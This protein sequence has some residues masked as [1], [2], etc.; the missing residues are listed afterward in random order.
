MPVNAFNICILL[1]LN[2]QNPYPI[3][4][5]IP[6]PLP[7]PI[8]TPLAPAKISS[9]ST[10]ALAMQIKC[11]FLDNMYKNT[12]RKLAPAGLSNVSVYS[13]FYPHQEKSLGTDSIDWLDIIYFF[14][15][16]AGTKTWMTTPL[17]RPLWHSNPN[18][19]KTD[20]R[21]SFC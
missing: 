5:Q 8:P 6:E 12:Q 11:I 18:R 4:L 19:P 15:Q 14:H 16:L 1:P 17:T 9:L 13:C 10:T 2:E 21:F 3:S 20:K 7:N